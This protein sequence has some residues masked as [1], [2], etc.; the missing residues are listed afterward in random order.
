[1]Y[2]AADGSIYIMTNNR[3]GRGNPRGDDDKIIRF[4]PDARR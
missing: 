1:V 2:E 4:R 3:D